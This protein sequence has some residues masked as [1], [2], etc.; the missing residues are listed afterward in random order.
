MNIKEDLECSTLKFQK[1]SCVLPCLLL[2]WYF[3]GRERL[4]GRSEKSEKRA[5]ERGGE[6]A[7]IWTRNIA[8]HSRLDSKNAHPPRT[9][10]QSWGK[11][12][13]KFDKTHANYEKARAI[14]PAAKSLKFCCRNRQKEIEAK[15][16]ELSKKATVFHEFRRNCAEWGRKN[17]NVLKS[18]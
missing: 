16:E 10:A 11:F 14:S 8:T 6:R 3:W 1:L 12:K 9:C 18:R 15:W 13:Q 17:T 5:R 7:S 2:F 4:N